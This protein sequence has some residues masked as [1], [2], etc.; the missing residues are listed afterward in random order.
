MRR[1]V[2]E[3]RRSLAR[4]YKLPRRASVMLVAKQFAPS[5]PRPLIESSTS[6]TMSVQAAAASPVHTPKK[7]PKKASK[8]KSAKIVA[9]HPTYSVMIKAALVALKDH[10]GSSRAAILKYILQHYKVGDNINKV[11]AHLRQ[12][13]KKGASSGFL[14]QV[15]GVGASG[16]FR[17][18][19][20]KAEVHKKVK[21][22]TA[23]KAHTVKS[24][25][26]AAAKKPAKPHKKAAG[27][28]KPKSPK[29]VK[30]AKKPAAVKPK[31]T[32]S[33]KKKVAKAKTP[34]KS[35]T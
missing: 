27:A 23:K 29:K 26:A 18:G 20:K 33:P 11:N 13:L 24:R 32:A 17:L 34:K 7:G 35:K 3:S 25:K 5:T 28:K 4:C 30:L 22:P 8:S 9:S 19:E 21:K 12:A 6:A 2:T 10:K 14:K 1:V 31:K 15:K 16:S